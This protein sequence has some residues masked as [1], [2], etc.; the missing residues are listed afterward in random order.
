MH[1]ALIPFKRGPKI[2]V[3]GKKIYKQFLIF[4][5]ISFQRLGDRFANFK[6]V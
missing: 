6:K 3:I 5:G 2:M 1:V 4:A